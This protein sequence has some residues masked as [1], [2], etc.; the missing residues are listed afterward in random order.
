MRKEHEILAAER[1]W[2]EVAKAKNWET[3]KTPPEAYMYSGTNV[4]VT[5]RYT[6]EYK[7][8]VLDELDLSNTASR[9]GVTPADMAVFK[10]V[11][12]RKAHVFWF[13][14]YPRTTLLHLL[15]DTIPTGP[16]VRTPPHRLK[17]EEDGWVTQKEE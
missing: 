13:E 5:A 12:T 16:P 8:K 14:G 3:I 7:K 1:H 6:E 4:D 10:E 11:C 15:H 17:G 2:K 9:E